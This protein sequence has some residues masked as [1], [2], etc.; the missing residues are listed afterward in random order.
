MFKHD[1]LFHLENAVKKKLSLLQKPNVDNHAVTC[2]CGWRGGRE[3]EHMLWV[4]L[5]PPASD[6][7]TAILTSSIS[8]CDLICKITADA[9]KLR[10]RWSEPL[11]QYDKFPYQKGKFVHRNMYRRKMA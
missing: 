7:Y 1:C 9:I 10:S 5:H 2:T 4:D 8:E 6:S 11:L 3:T